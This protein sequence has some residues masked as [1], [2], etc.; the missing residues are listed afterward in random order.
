MSSRLDLHRELMDFILDVYFQPPSNIK[1][2]HP[3]IVYHKV[4]KIREYAND[5]L[6]LGKQGYQ[7]TLMETDP[8]SPIADAMEQYFQYCSITQHFAMDNLNQTVLTL[9]Y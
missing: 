5:G 7:V 8:D 6:Y 1:L 2:T 4:N 3:C 9:Y